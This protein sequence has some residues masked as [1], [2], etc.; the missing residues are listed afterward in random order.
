VAGQAAQLFLVS[1]TS[2][3]VAA[4]KPPASAALFEQGLLQIL[5]AAATG[6]QP[7]RPYVLALSRRPDGRGVLEPPA[8]F[9]TNPAGAAVVKAVG[10][11][12]QIVRGEEKTQRRYL[13][14]APGTASQY[15]APVQVQSAPASK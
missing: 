6:L 14:I 9:T 10:P 13:V 7:G 1:V 11:I 15:S 5:Q 12:R 8:A 2:S 3:R 4:E